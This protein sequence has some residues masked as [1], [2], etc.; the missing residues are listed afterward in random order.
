[1]TTNEDTWGIMNRE[2]LEHG[3][4]A[5]TGFRA[6]WQK[7]I[8]F[9]MWHTCNDYDCGEMGEHCPIWSN[10]DNEVIARRKARREQ[11]IWEN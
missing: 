4:N 8:P 5:G 11:Y 7:I 6:R 9:Q 3:R 2:M 10:T 1:M